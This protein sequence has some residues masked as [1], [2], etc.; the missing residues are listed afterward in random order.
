MSDNK[1]KVSGKQKLSSFMQKTADVT[2][3]VAKDAYDGTKVMAEKIKENSEKHKFEKLA[4]L[5]PDDYLS[6]DFKIPNVIKIVDDATRKNIEMCQGAIGWL[7]ME[8]AGKDNSQK[9]EV[10]YLYDETREMCGLQFVPS[11]NIN[12]IYC[13]DTFDLSKKRFIKADC[14]FNKAQEEK[15]AELEKVAYSLGA[16]SYSVDI[17]SSESDGVSKRQSTTAKVDQEGATVKNSSSNSNSNHSVGH[18]SATFEGHNSPVAPK[19]KWFMYDDTIKNLIEMRCADPA[20]VKSRTLE[21]S[22]ASSATMSRQT[23]VAIDCMIKGAKVK[24]S[25]DME[26][27]ANKE[28]SSTLVFKIEF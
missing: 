21:L 15:L 13:I 4:P 24:S 12:A 7:A 10:L 19:L 20:S 22:G 28:L 14:I 8:G 16:K 17:V 3:K 6:E 9:T 18:S 26:M 11:F 1:E 25:S 23:A 2:K 27:Q 5:F